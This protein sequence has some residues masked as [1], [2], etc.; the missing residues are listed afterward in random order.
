ME[1]CIVRV[2]ND[3]GEIDSQQLKLIFSIKNNHNK[4]YCTESSENAAS[5]N[6]DY[7]H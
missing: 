4:L 6:C 7:F 2:V 5:S 1:F 3:P